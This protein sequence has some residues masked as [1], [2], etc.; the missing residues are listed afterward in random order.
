LRLEHTIYP[1]ATRWNAQNR[2]RVVQG[3]VYLDGAA[4]P[5]FTENGKPAAAAKLAAVH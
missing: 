3:R 1:R 2:I 5:V 4:P